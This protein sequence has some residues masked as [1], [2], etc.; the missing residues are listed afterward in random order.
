MT[1]RCLVG[2]HLIPRYPCPVHRT[3][4]RSTVLARAV[5]AR[6]GKCWRCGTTRN[7]EAAHIVPK[8]LGGADTMANM[9]AECWALNRTGRCER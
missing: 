3:D 4:K 8:A 9:R 1:L 2:N 6:D 5:I 7:L